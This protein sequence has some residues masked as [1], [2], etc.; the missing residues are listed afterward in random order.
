MDKRVVLKDKIILFLISLD[1]YKNDFTYCK[2]KYAKTEIVSFINI[3][4]FETHNFLSHN[5]HM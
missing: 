4:Y 5:M 3:I 2:A 1:T